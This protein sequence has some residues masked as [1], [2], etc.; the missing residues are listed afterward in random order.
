MNA[1]RSLI[2]VPLLALL[3]ACSSTSRTPAPSPLPV[4]S[5][6]QPVQ[7]VWR[8]S[9]GKVEGARLQPAIHGNVVAALNGEKRLML[10]DAGTGRDLWQA[11]LPA[12]A[13][14]G[15]GLG[16][17]LVVTG[18]LKGEIFAYDSTG[19][20]RWTSRTSSAVAAAPV[21]AGSLVLV[22]GTD[23]RLT[24][25]SAADGS[26]V[27]FY[28]RQQP[29]LLLRS[30][31]QPV[32]AGDVI[33]YGQAG[34][35]LAALTLREGRVLWEAQVAQPRGVSEL[36]R[37]ADVVTPPVVGGG[38][39]CAVAYQGRLACFN[40]QNGAFAWSREVSSFSGLGM[41]GKA[42]YVTDD[43]G[44]V[45]AYERSGGRNQWRQD[46][47]TGRQVSGPALIGR[48]LLVGD[49]QGYA[50]FIDTED[51]SLVARHATDGGAIAMPPV[52]AG[53]RWL[54]Q[55]QKGSLVMLGLKEAQ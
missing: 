27:W 21:V 9:L 31:A 16:D 12:Q 39:A 23:G 11:D 14:G 8:R 44:N 45:A 37:I 5:G 15:V 40:A 36:E 47:L 42:V 35:K 19:K 28:A 6:K 41:D 20:L 2:A 4:V 32:V 17:D 7:E 3:A 25:Y 10:L 48:T 49:Y 24:A 38:L 46:K 22:R 29:A 55:T 33:Y 26:A 53:T 43:K 1:C 34:G 30:Y 18:S 51:G 13:S 54:V 52:K 50:H